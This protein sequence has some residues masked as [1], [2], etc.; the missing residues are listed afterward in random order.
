M[1]DALRA[2]R[3]RP[4]HTSAGESGTVPAAS[5][6]SRQSR[7]P[8]EEEETGAHQAAFRIDARSR[9]RRASSRIAAGARDRAG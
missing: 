6:P 7:R 9:S 3:Q 8:P 2:R 5:P 1:T 4:C